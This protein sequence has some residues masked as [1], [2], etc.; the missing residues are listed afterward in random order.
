MASIISL[1]STYLIPPL[2]RV[3]LRRVKKLIKRLDNRENVVIV[4]RQDSGNIFLNASENISG[5]PFGHPMAEID[6]MSL[7]F[8]K[9]LEDFGCQDKICFGGIPLYDIY[10]R[11]VRLKLAEVL[12]CAL[13][14][15][16]WSS[17]SKKSIEVVADRQTIAIL[18]KAVEFIGTSDFDKKIKWNQS[19]ILT[20]CV[21]LNSFSMRLLSF[22]KTILSKNKLPLKYYYKGVNP[23]KPT[24]LI[25]MPPTNT[26]Q[27]FSFYIEKLG[28][29]FNIALYSLGK[30]ECDLNGF[31]ILSIPSVKRKFH[32]ALCLF[33]G[34]GVESYIADIV[35]IYN[36]HA[37]LAA[38]VEV[39]KKI[40]SSHKIDV[41]I[42]RQQVMAINN[43]FVSESKKRNIFILCDIFEEVYQCDAG[44]VSSKLNYT[45]LI[46]KATH[47]KKI[48]FKESNDLIKY[49]MHLKN[50]NVNNYV[51]NLLEIDKSKHVIFYA[52]DPSK[53]ERQRYDQ[54]RF[55]YGQ[56]SKCND[57]ILVVKTH[58]QDNGNITHLAYKSCNSP[59]NIILIGDC[60]QKK[61]ISKDFLLFPE[62]NFHSAICSCNGFITS[63]SS[64]ILEALALNIKS[65]ILDTKN[66]YYYRDL[67]D[68]KALKLINKDYSIQD[69]INEKKWKIPNAALKYCGLEKDVKFDVP[70]NYEIII[71]EEL[72]VK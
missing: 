6:A 62:F 45:P 5:I 14:L 42:N 53:E 48:I 41:L 68:L 47:L 66:H 58:R 50:N 18:V 1:S 34:F 8:Y 65:G 59:H 31:K 56:M 39:P 21:F 43:Q 10:T 24:I 17:I 22:V 64:S 69:F 3:Y 35:L 33:N 51:H 19:N 23:K 70:L 38:C 15:K 32:G 7:E 72:K 67:V 60:L 30:L 4:V 52:S 55:L 46:Q 25:T 57:S 12:K 36:N 29:K 9:Y 13:Q 44:I 40:F 2:D 26:E 54:E 61:M 11:Q 28:N 20:V 63:S 16:N 49:R 71:K 37:N 27:F